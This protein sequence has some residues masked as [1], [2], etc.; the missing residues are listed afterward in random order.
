MRKS[1]LIIL[2]VILGLVALFTVQNPD[3]VTVK[4]FSFDW[5][6]SKLVLIV[7]SFAAGLLSGLLVSVTDYFR[8]R[9]QAA[10]AKATKKTN[11]MTSQ[12]N[13]P[14]ANS[15]A[16]DLEAEVANLKAEIAQL[17]LKVDVSTKPPSPEDIG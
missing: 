5:N 11:Q 13:Q 17:K 3:I 12:A 4:F 14:E 15:A 10:E 16:R 2:V 8:K 9:I 7:A 1:S 6:T